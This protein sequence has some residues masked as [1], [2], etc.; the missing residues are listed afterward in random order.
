MGGGNQRVT[1]A[2]SEAGRL[3]LRQYADDGASITAG[4]TR[5]LGALS[6]E[7]TGL[8][9]DGG[10]LYLAGNTA[11]G[12]LNAGTVARAY[13]GGRDG[14][15]AKLS[16]DLTSGAGD[17]ISYIGGAGEDS[18]AGISIVSGEIYLGGA[19]TKTF[20]GALEFGAQDGYVARLD[21]SGQLAWTQRLASATKFNAATFVAD[22]GGASALDRLGLPQGLID[23]IDATDLVSRTSLRV[24]DEF[25]IAVNGRTAQTIKI[26]AGDTLQKLADKVE[27]VILSAGVGSVRWRPPGMT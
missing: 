20:G 5:D 10:D 17:R 23:T 11:F 19:S 15:V 27:R 24:G 14:F 25:S 18:V 4:T 6:G 21:T 9:L 2:S 8:V 22:G 12:G 3:V 7:I 16:G 26:A 1:L 13:S